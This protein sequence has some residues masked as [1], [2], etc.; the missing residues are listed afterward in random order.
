MYR[1]GLIS[2]E[3]M[4]THPYRNKIYNCLGGDN[5]PQIDLADRHEL[6]D[7][8]IILLCTDGIWNVIDDR[9]IKN[10]L[11][12]GV[13]DETIAHL[14]DTSE[15]NSDHTGDNMSA[16]GLQWGD[17]QHNP[18]AVSTI[19]MPLDQTTTIMNPSTQPSK[20]LDA[21]PDDLTDDEIEKTIAE[22][23]AALTRPKSF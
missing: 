3:E 16:I 4:S 22:I 23:Q 9:E 17:R 20:L 14:L 12:S 19:T 13:I 21:A 11:V 15:K 5:I 1:K 18:Q 6:Q 7:G 2:K 8:D 10:I